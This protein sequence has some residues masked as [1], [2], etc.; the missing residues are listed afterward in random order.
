MPPLPSI[1]RHLGAFK[2]L[3]DQLLGLTTLYDGHA[4][5]A[6]II[7]QALALATQIADGLEDLKASSATVQAPDPTQ[8]SASPF[9]RLDAA[10]VDQSQL[11]L[12]VTGSVSR[13]GSSSLWDRL[14]S[15]LKNLIFSFTSHFTR[16]VNDVAVKVDRLDWDERKSLCLEIFDAD[17]IP[18]GAHI[19]PAYIL[20]ACEMQ[21]FLR[22]KSRSMYE[23]VRGFVRAYEPTC[24]LRRVAIHRDW[25]DLV[26]TEFTTEDLGMADVPLDRILSIIQQS[27]RDLSIDYHLALGSAK[28]GRLDVL[29]CTLAFQSCATQASQIVDAAVLG[30]HTHILEWIIPKFKDVVSIDCAATAGRLDIVQMIHQSTT[31][32]ATTVAMDYA[33][34]NGHLDVVKSGWLD[35]VMYL[36]QHRI[37]GCNGDA[38]ISAAMNGHLEVVEFLCEFAGLPCTLD[39]LIQAACNGHFKAAEYIYR[40]LETKPHGV[41]ADFDTV[42]LDGSA[43]VL[44]FLVTECGILPSKDAVCMVLTGKLPKVLEIK[45]KGFHPVA[46]NLAFELGLHRTVTFEEVFAYH[47]PAPSRLQRLAEGCDD[48]QRAEMA[49]ALAKRGRIDSIFLLLSRWSASTLA[50]ISLEHIQVSYNRETILFLELL[51]A[52]KRSLFEVPNLSDL[53]SDL[54]AQSLY[55]F[56]YDVVDWIRRRFPDIDLAGSACAIDAGDL[57]VLK[58]RAVSNHS[59]ALETAMKCGCLSVVRWLRDCYKGP[60][61]ELEKRIIEAAQRVE[62]IGS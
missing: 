58:K 37:G 21:D 10:A 11:T 51:L 56:R 18:L 49:V 38:L 17:W 34:A 54:L 13:A 29:Q 8:I 39:A 26:D 1:T 44:R 15:E 24:S 55:T 40:R 52:E 57:A 23:F 16:L 47:I 4:A 19:K 3:A 12:T 27:S 30:N 33:A 45:R 6:I 41:K 60:D 53:L 50:K 9:R 61:K 5:P 36:H 31:A 43:D 42:L 28:I 2:S 59:Q 48:A 14:S 20:H 35:V 22:I 7:D 25:L 46:V 62:G 32:R